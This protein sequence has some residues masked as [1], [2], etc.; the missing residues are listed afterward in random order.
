MRAYPLQI[1]RVKYIWNVQHRFSSKSL[2]HLLILLVDTVVLTNND[3]F[4]ATRAS[5]ASVA[6]EVFTLLALLKDDIKASSIPQI[7]NSYSGILTNVLIVKIFL[8]A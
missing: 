2:T 6:S 3:I 8:L 1:N 7:F 4:A 5:L